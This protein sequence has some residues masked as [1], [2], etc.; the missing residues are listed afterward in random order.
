MDRC[1]G[2]CHLDPQALADGC[3][4]SAGSL[5]DAAIDPIDVGQHWHGGPH[6]PRL[7]PN[8]GAAM[9]VV[10]EFRRLP[11]EPWGESDQASVF[12][13]ANSAAGLYWP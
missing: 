6:P 9:T 1:H 13:A 7:H 2:N 3:R 8:T 12:T 10:P 11:K 5:P 4:V